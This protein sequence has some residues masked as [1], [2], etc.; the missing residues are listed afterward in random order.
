MSELRE[1]RTVFQALETLYQ[2]YLPKVDSSLIHDLLM[3]EHE[4]SERAP[5]YMVEIF[6][7]PKI[8]SDNMKEIIYQKTGMI[9]SIH[10]NGTHYVTNQ[11]LTLETLKEICDSE[12]VVEVTGDYTGTLTGRGASHEPRGHAH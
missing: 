2:T 7:K 11:R 8:D 4:K 9:P 10:D 1:I 5:F 6:T 3:R 12:D